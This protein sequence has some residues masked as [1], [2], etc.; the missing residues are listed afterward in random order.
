MQQPNFP[1]LH[2]LHSMGLSTL[3]ILTTW[4]LGAFSASGQ[5]ITVTP[6]G[7]GT[8]ITID[9]STYHIEGGTQTGANLFHSFQDFGLSP[10]E[11]ADFFSQPN[12]INIFGRVT[13]GN[14]SIIDGLIRANPNLYLMN[15]AGIVFGANASLNV[16]GDFFA[17]T[18]DQIC[19]EDVC[20]NS[21]GLN[22]YAS[23]LGNPTT[24]GF[25]QSQP[26]SLMNA[27]TLEVLKGKSIHLSGG[28]VVNLGQIAAPGGIATVAAIP[29]ERRVRLNQ[30]GSLLSLNVTDEVLTTGIEPLA[31][32]ELLATAPEHL[33]AKAVSASLGNVAIGGEIIAE[34]IDLYAAGQVTPG[35][36]NLIKGK[37]RVTRFSERGENPNQAVFIDRRA[38][39]PEDLLYGAEAGTVT[40]IIEKDEKGIAV[41]SEQLAVISEAV[42]ELDSVAIVAEGNAGNFWLGSQWI[43]AE[44]IA[45]YQTQLQTWSNT[46]TE[47]A[48]ILLYSCFTALG[49]T[50]EALIASI[51]NFTGADVSASV[52]AT[53][54][55]N[56]GGDWQL[57]T[58]IG[59]IEASNPFTAQTVGNWE[60]K[61][62]THTVD[63][64]ADDGSGG[65]TLRE[66]IAA[67]T[68]GD[69]VVFD[70]ARTVIL[71]GTEI[72]WNNTK[73]NL[74]IE[75]NGSTVDGNN[76][77]R[78]FNISANNAT[79]N[80]LTIQNGTVGGTDSGAGILH[81][82]SGTI[83]LNRATISE[84]STMFSQGRGGGIHST[85]NL[86]LNSSMIS[87]NSTGQHGGGIYGNGTITVN[88]STISGN[89][90]FDF[91]G[92]MYGR[93]TTIV[94]DSIISGNSAYYGGGIANTGV[95]TV[96]N[97]TISE[98]YSL[99]G[100]SI[101]GLGASSNITVN[102][103]T[104]SNNS[105][106]IR[107]GAGLYNSGGTLTVNSSTLFGNSIFAAGGA[108][109]N[110]NGNLYI[111]NSTIS[112]NSAGYFGGAIQSGNGNITI[113]SSTIA[114]NV[115]DANNNGIGD[116]GGISFFGTGT[117][118]I[119]SSIIANNIDLGGES[120][121]ID[122]NLTGTVHNNLIQSTLGSTG[123][124]ANGNIIGQDPL[125]GPLANNGGATQTHALLPGSPAIDAGNN[126]GVAA[127]DQAGQP[128]ISNGTVDL[129]PF[130]FQVTGDSPSLTPEITNEMIP[131]DFTPLEPLNALK[132]A[133]TATNS[134]DRVADFLANSQICEAAAA[135]DN[136][137]TQEF[138]QHFGRFQVTQPKTCAELQQRLP[139][140]AALLYLFAQTDKVHLI[141]LRSEGEP[142]HYERPIPRMAI[143]EQVT[144]LQQAITNPVLRRS[145]QFLAPAQTLYQWVV[146]P[147]LSEFAAHDIRNILFSLDEGVRTLPIA[148]LHNGQE[149]LLEDYQTTL[150][151]SLSLTPTHHSRL[152][153]ASVL[154]LGISAFEQFAPLP[155]VPVELASIKEQF[156]STAS[157]SEAQATLVNFQRQLQQSPSQVVHLAT[158]GNFRPGQMQNSYIQ[159]WDG[160]LNLAQIE[161]V[162]WSMADVELLV[163]SACQTALGDKAVEYGFAGLAVQAE[164][165]AAVAGLWSAHDAA[166]LALMS[167][168][169]RQLSLG[170]PKGEA[171]R[172]A[173]LAL[174]N[175]TVRLE[176]KQ[177]IG[178]SKDIPLPQALQELGDR[179][180]WHPYY[181]SAFTL[182]GNPW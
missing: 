14:A 75:G 159:F 36:P 10:G 25:L 88:N 168:F 34:H 163:L 70:S 69:M 56:Y 136:Y 54:S 180:F 153:N 44:N 46:L 139:D 97:S 157:L 112:G 173:Q 126:S 80:D 143:V 119:G 140:D 120:P 5:S 55:A 95:L 20:F 91:G 178:V 133:K 135:L 106:V 130:E 127:T 94:T 181:W 152:A 137:Y 134:R 110:V 68:T 169:Y 48:D 73:D 71:N 29:G 164:A 142:M 98:N 108:I 26:G 65:T 122:G 19:F 138:N 115:A 28:T 154:A 158:H 3:L 81:S 109:G 99:Y 76:V 83:T 37:T 160:R 148:A 31:L 176:N 53:G 166:T 85:G 11:I 156:P 125:L 123:I 89:L 39:N 41:V 167:E 114:F 100:G 66:A 113:T 121:D 32:P 111:N 60:G 131:L 101:F 51:A 13:G 63:S 52:D 96:T 24:L 59:E 146:E 47:N 74:T 12:I 182:I 72:A 104:I 57:E 84:N 118:R 21:V 18:A 6:D 2:L 7:T 82:G 103:S 8:V 42:G 116:G 92:G 9:G 93:G 179:T 175:G 132:L 15:P 4:N 30:P 33:Q 38:D 151:P 17:T 43:T 141:S 78:V 165:G 1:S 155:A 67:A 62:L 149:F 144:G 124:P 45:D 172:Q 147:L 58:N 129:G 174:L 170:L 105:A 145:E 128:R 177:L 162:D 27:G 86:T 61:L 171:L 150:I 79:I 102:S 117:H 35:N 49:A 23:L 90:T 161:Q 40:Q 64:S 16:G 87:G 107:H 22:D 77:S 50:G